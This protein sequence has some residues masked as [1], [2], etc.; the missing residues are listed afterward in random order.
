MV[1]LKNEKYR[2]TFKVFAIGNSFSDDA[3]EYLYQI[4]E[5]SGIEDIKIGNLYIGGC[6]LERHWNNAEN[7]DSAYTYRKNTDG[8]FVEKTLSIR[9]ALI[10][11]EWKIIVFQQASGLSGIID[12]YEPYLSNLKEYVKK[13]MTN[14]RA[15]FAWHMTWAYQSNSTHEEFANYNNNQQTMYDA[16]V[17]AVQTKIVP[18]D[19]FSFIIPTGTAVQNMRNSYIGDNLTRD[20]FHMSIP[21]GRYVAGLT[22]FKI[23]TG[24]LL[25]NVTYKPFGMNETDEKIAKNSV[26]KA[27]C[28]PFQVITKP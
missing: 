21:L 6:S 23:L 7:D 4:A 26:N 2:K 28:T 8:S 1:N 17:N 22:W 20:G 25:E 10:D 16:I 5:S 13:N 12:S 24:R 9:E 14:L 15:K 19:D 3:V 11:E 27:I 18:D